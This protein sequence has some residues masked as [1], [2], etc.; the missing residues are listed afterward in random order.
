MAYCPR[1]NAKI[2]LKAVRCPECGYDFPSPTPKKSGIAYSWLADLALFV[3]CFCASIYCIAIL[4]GIVVKTLQGDF[5]DAFVTAP[6]M[7][8]LSLAML[9]VFLRM[10]DQGSE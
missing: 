4:V 7:F 5:F 8:F 10:A 1:C 2:G 3:G 6:L 9:V